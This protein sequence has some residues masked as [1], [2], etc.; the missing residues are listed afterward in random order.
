[1]G[2]ADKKGG[3][4]AK[5]AHEE[6]SKARRMS[7]V[8]GDRLSDA[9]WWH[10]TPI[11]GR[12]DLACFRPVH[13]ERQA[14]ELGVASLRAAIS[15]PLHPPAVRSSGG[16]LI[17]QEAP[18]PPATPAKATGAPP[19]L[20]EELMEAGSG[21]AEP[22]P[23]AVGPARDYLDAF[24]ICELKKVTQTLQ[25]GDAAAKTQTPAGMESAYEC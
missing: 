17:P 3:R 4:S 19:D 18:A 9:T 24:N 25:R 5:A 22:T 2:E 21:H 10:G 12:E 16:F 13:H 6:D 23:A 7:G 1:M 14:K 8:S 11:D 20:H 15:L